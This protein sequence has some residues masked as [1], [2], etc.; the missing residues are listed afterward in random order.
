MTTFVRVAEAMLAEEMI[1]QSLLACI[2]LAAHD[3]SAV[4]PLKQA[5]SEDMTSQ[6]YRGASN[7]HW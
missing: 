4:E 2:R 3:T 5:I 7:V 6:T 1:T